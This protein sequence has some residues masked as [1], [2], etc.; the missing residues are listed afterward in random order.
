LTFLVT[1][2]LMNIY[3]KKYDLI[4]LYRLYLEFKKNKPLLTPESVMVFFQWLADREVA[5]DESNSPLDS[6]GDSEADYQ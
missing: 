5:E 3:M 1:Y 2:G 4:E 6:V